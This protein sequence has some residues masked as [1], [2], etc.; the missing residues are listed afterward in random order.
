[1]KKLAMLSITV[2]MLLVLAACGNNNSDNENGGATTEP[3]S[4]TAPTASPTASADPT[5]APA[6]NEPRTITYLGTE[7]TVPATA[8]KLVITG[9]VESLEDA[10]LLDVKPAGALTIGGVFP[11][12]FAPITGE[13]EMVGEKSQPN[14][15]AILKLKPDVILMSTKFPAETIEKMKEIG[16]TIPVSHIATDWEANLALLGELT[17]KQD[18]VQEVLAKYK[19]DAAALEEKIG[20]ALKDKKVLAIRV[21]AGNL[22]I[23]PADVFFNPS[24]YEDLGATVPA[25][26]TAAKAQQQITLEK[27]S[28]MNPDY[29][30][31]QFAED[32]NKDTP[33]VFEELQANPIFQAINAS[34]EGHVYTNI[35]DPLLQGGTA[36]SKISFLE[37][38]SAL[39]LAGE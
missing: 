22:F 36:Y 30:F 25:D 29:L 10:L 15:E 21:R 19:T 1:M 23:Y 9:S 6:S 4:S 20:P 35:V 27:L 32:E 5:E 11:E 14:M 33:K 18:K 3:T 2:V 8:E 13:S 39:N 28:E 7:Y 26:V 38:I 24:L 12:V 37:A 17:G 16:P 31:V 34:K